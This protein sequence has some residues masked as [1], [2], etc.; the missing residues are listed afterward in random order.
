MSNA[1]RRPSLEPTKTTPPDTAGDDETVPGPPLEPAAWMVAFHSGGQ[2]TGAPAEELDASASK[3]TR[4]P[5]V[6]GDVGDVADDGR[7]GRDRR[8][9]GTVEEGAEPGHVGLGE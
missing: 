9:G 3:A 2:L 4:V 7:R 5:A 1:S 8:A 6:G